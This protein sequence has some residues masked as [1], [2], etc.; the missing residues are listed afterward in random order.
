[1]HVCVLIHFKWSK[2]TVL[3]NRC[4]ILSM[5]GKLEIFVGQES[6]CS[7]HIMAFHHSHPEPL[8]HKIKITLVEW[9]FF[10]AAVGSFSQSFL[11][12]TDTSKE[13]EQFPLAWRRQQC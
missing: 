6:L 5:S 4:L 9:T 8:S 13:A 2:E 12:T 7:D 11:D 1:M 3:G 10:K